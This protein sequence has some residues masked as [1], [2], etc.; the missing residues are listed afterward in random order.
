MDWNTARFAAN[1]IY[2]VAVKNF[3]GFAIRNYGSDQHRCVR[4]AM[5]P[6]HVFMGEYAKHSSGTDHIGNSAIPVAESPVR[7]AKK[8]LN[9]FLAVA[10][11][12]AKE[13]K[14]ANCTSRAANVLRV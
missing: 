1:R 10:V 11:K 8:R 14:L 5:M 2:A 12:N 3:A 6:D 9:G 13:V 7:S 4:V